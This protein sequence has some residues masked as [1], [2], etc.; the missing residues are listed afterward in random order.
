M[1]S[2]NL[3]TLLLLA[4]ILPTATGICE[5]L[6]FDS[7]GW[8]ENKIQFVYLIFSA[9]LSFLLYLHFGFSHATSVMFADVSNSNLRLFME[10]IGIPLL[11]ELSML[12]AG[13]FFGFLVWVIFTVVAL[14]PSD[15]HWAIWLIIILGTPS[16]SF[17][18]MAFS[19]KVLARSSFESNFPA[20]ARLTRL[21]LHSG[22]FCNDV[23]PIDPTLPR[24]EIL[25][26]LAERALHHLE[27]P[28]S[29]APPPEEHEEDEEMEEAK[30]EPP[31]RGVAWMGEVVLS[32][33][34]ATLRREANERLAECLARQRLES[35]GAL[36]QAWSEAA[37]AS[38]KAAALERRLQDSAGG[39]E[40]HLPTVMPYDASRPSTALQVEDRLKRLD[41]AKIDA[42]Q[43]AAAAAPAPQKLGSAEVLTIETSVDAEVLAAREGRKGLFI[44]ALQQQAKYWQAE[45]FNAWCRVFLQDR[46]QQLK[47]LLESRK[48]ASA[49]ATPRK[50]SNEAACLLKGLRRQFG[51]F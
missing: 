43:P 40:A 44:A 37:D 41:A 50:R 15:A 2:Y 26:Q 8:P 23:I 49:P 12:F 4:T 47:S 33:S 14:I 6:E 32:R 7:Q 24:K 42:A 48:K 3:L 5:S 30:A 20:I 31:Y 16:I 17:L 51:H 11:A 18:I 39:G 25:E 29:V 36:H 35:R 34:T 45:A 38:R 10:A 19:A 13:N 27:K 22:L 9:T 28:Q 46:C 1:D 21:Q